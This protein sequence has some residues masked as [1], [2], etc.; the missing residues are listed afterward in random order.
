MPMP[1]TSQ[2]MIGTILAL[3]VAAAAYRAHALTISGAISAA[4]IG[5]LIFGLGGWPW[6]APLLTFFVTSSLLS[7]WRRT[8]KARLGFEKTGRRDAAQVWANGGVASACAL[9]QVFPHHS[10]SFVLFLAA[11]AAANAD[12]WATEIGA[13]IG[14]IPLD[15]R[16]G[17]RAAVGTSGA[18]SLG[19]TLAALAGAALIALFAWPLG[20]RAVGIVTI[21]GLGGALLDSV[22]GATV[23]AQWRDASEADRWT[24]RPQA[25]L[26]PARGWR[27]INNDWV[28]FA[29]TLFAACLVQ[30]IK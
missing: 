18:I 27:L 11:L 14:G 19:G 23:Q 24:E 8:Q 25:D 17:K 7:R 22:L 10:A 30:I 16:T 21:G 4:V 20:V 9:W 13:A 5:A 15:L 6:A 1:Q 2:I 26:K 29:A 3:T 12:T 28:N